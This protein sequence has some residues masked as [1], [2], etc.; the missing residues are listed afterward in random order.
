[1]RSADASR[2]SALLQSAAKN[3]DEDGDAADTTVAPEASSYGS[4]SEGI[5]DLLED[6]RGKAE[7][8][9]EEARKAEAEQQH[10]YELVKQALVDEMKVTSKDMSAAKKSSAAAAEKKA[11]AEGELET[12]QN[13]LAEDLRTLEELRR[14]CMS[15]AQD[16]EAETVSLGQELKALA[17]AKKVLE[18]AMG[19]AASSFRQVSLLQVSSSQ[20]ATGLQAVHIVRHL[21]EDQKIRSLGRLALEMEALL[22]GESGA[23]DPFEKVKGLLRDMLDKLTSEADKEATHKAFCDKAMAENNAEK[24]AVSTESAKLATKMEQA[25]ARSSMLKEEV[26][27]LQV[28][29]AKM[30]HAQAVM[31]AMRLNEKATYETNKR[32]HEKGLLGIRLSLKI[33]RDYYGASADSSHETSDGAAGGIVSLLEV[34]ESNF[35]RGLAEVVAVEEAA[36][37]EYDA[38]TQEMKL[39]RVAKDKDVSFKTKEAIALDKTATEMRSDRGHIESQLSAVLE[40]LRSLEQQCVAKADSYEAKTARRQAELDGLKSALATLG[41]GED[42]AASFLQ[43][44]RRTHAARHGGALRGVLRVAA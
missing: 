4:Q 41:G 5:A 44:G 39:A 14:N 8:Q 1:V 36:Q 24:E 17:E 38:E 32:D 31:D 35:S 26:G 18:E 12:T 10:N 25:T 34:C 30:A 29:L 28:E 40:A 16:F 23:G 11:T 9:L 20:L 15:H 42:G 43:S 6:L 3:E 33:L 13:D 19:G 22:Q 7:D 2:L 27:V 37:R 21:A